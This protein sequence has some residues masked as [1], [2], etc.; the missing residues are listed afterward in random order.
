MKILKIFLAGVIILA[1]ALCGFAPELLGIDPRS[2]THLAFIL[3]GILLVITSCLAI[4]FIKV[5][6]ERKKGG[7]NNASM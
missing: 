2:K 3:L 4:C 5:A 1:L 6:D 7:G